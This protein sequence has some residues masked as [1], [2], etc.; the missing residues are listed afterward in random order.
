MTRCSM[1]RKCDAFVEK[2]VPGQTNGQ[3]SNLRTGNKCSRD[4]HVNTMEVPESHTE[5]SD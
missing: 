2:G 1:R 5:N 4:V 3:D